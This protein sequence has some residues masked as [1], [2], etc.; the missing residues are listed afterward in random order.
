MTAI[1]LESS[2][3][4]ARP[5]GE[6]WNF[7]I[8][9]DNEKLWRS[10]V[11]D[12]RMTSDAPYGIGSTGIHYVKFLGTV[13]WRII[14]WEE[15]RVMEWVFLDGMIRDYHGSHVLEPVDDGT[16]MTV[17]GEIA[18]GFP[19]GIMGILLKPVFTRLLATDL[20]RLKSIMEKG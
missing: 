17:R 8:K 12:A 9:I 14:K 6:V 2:V 7:V 1:P 10:G 19:F 3:F 20:K 5:A 16:R 18:G 13:R 15:H 11:T 4:I